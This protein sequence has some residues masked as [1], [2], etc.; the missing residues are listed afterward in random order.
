MPKYTRVRFQTSA[1]LTVARMLPLPQDRADANERRP[2]YGR[3]P[4]ILA[5]SHRQL[6]HSVLLGEFA[7]AAE[8]RARRLRVAG[9]RRHRHQAADVRIATDEVG[10]AVRAHARLRRL[11]GEVDLDGRGNAEPLRGRL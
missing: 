11:A 4:V 7:Q 10:K 2:L 6:A 1:K 9:R 3:N 8:K 5:R